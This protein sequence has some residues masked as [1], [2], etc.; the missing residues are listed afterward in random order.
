MAR[1]R[2]EKEAPPVEEATPP[3][4]AAP[5]TAAADET[6]AAS[7]SG[8]PPSK[9][10]MVREALK[11]MGNDASTEDI[12]DF[13]LR[14]WGEPME[15]THISSYKSTFLRKEKE[16]EK[17]SGKKVGRPRGSSSRPAGEN[18]AAPTP[19]IPVDLKYIRSIRELVDQIGA[20]KFRELV[21]LLYPPRGEAAKS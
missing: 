9:A 17:G 13:L 7:T 3:E 4:Y 15:K 20:N 6:P 19:A 11:A 2:K 5:A 10:A 12:Q 14:H 8:R 1:P 16:K 18:G 21:D